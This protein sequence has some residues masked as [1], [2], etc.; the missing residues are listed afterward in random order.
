MPNKVQPVRQPAIPPIPDT[1][2]VFGE[3]M[4]ICFES[5]MLGIA[6]RLALPGFGPD[7]FG[8]GLALRHYDDFYLRGVANLARGEKADGSDAVPDAPADEIEL[9][10]RAR[11]HLPPEVFDVERWKTAAG[12]A[13][14]PKVVH[15]LNRGGRIEEHDRAYLPDGLVR[16][17]YG[18]CLNLYQ[19]KTALV[20]HAGT[21]RRHLG[22]AAHVPVRDFL[23]REPAAQREGYPLALITHRTISQTKSR[24]MA[25][26]WLTPLM[27]ENGVLIHP[28]DAARLGLR[29]EQRVRVVSAT[30]ERGVWPL[31]EGDEQPMIGKLIFTQTIRP[32][33]VSFALGFGHWAAGARDV[34]IDGVLVRGEERRRKGLHAN[35]AMWTDPHVKNTC[36]FDPVGGS[37]SFYDTW[38]NL[39][40]A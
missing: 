39:V 14:W 3:K 26:P 9:F 37:V 33:V 31:A 23:G 16:H 38:V 19:E 32:G 25:D 15:V 28:S 8:P 10:L 40:P 7:A 6:E 30:N 4:P 2:A 24:T 11:R 34:V 20:I 17:A 18:K 27:P 35:A 1:C 22:H 12:D 13:L 21:G 29:N 5:L 36:L